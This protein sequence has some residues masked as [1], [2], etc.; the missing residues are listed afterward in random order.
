MIEL[1]L[2]RNVIV[3]NKTDMPMIKEDKRKIRENA[4]CLQKEM[5]GLVTCNM[6]V[7]KVLYDF[8]VSVSTAKC[9]SYTAQAE[10]TK[11]GTE[12]M[13]NFQL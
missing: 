1:N 6:Q 4:A 2:T 11:A 7:S 13:K 3:N 9:S 8:F 10:K 12:R 5:G